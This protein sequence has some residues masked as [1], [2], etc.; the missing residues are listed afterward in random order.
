MQKES[1][2]NRDEA[3]DKCTRKTRKEG[4]LEFMSIDEKIFKACSK[5]DI[6]DTNVQT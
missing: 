4:A 6:V 5:I 2:I 3:Q 1:Y